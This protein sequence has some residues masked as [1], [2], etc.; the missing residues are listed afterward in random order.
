MTHKHIVKNSLYN[1][2]RLPDGIQI[3]PVYTSFFPVPKTKSIPVQIG[4]ANTFIL[5]VKKKCIFVDEHQSQ[6][7]VNNGFIRNLL[8]CI[9]HV[10]INTK[11]TKPKV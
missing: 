5:M 7:K 4:T 1:G 9:P 8:P 10:W 2:C 3:T 6:I 11:T